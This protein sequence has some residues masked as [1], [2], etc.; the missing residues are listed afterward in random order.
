MKLNFSDLSGT[1]LSGISLNRAVIILTNLENADLTN[2]HLVNS[3]LKL[4]NLNGASL[5]EADIAY[6]FL[7]STKL[8]RTNFSCA[9][10]QETIFAD[11]D[12]SQA[13]A[14]DEVVHHGPSTIGIDSIFRSQ[15]NIPK[16][17]L[18]GA[19]V[20]DSFIQYAGSSIQS[21]TQY[22]SCFI[23]HS[24]KNQ[25]F[26]DRL[27]ADFKNNNVR[28]WLATE[29]LKI[30]DRFR[31]RIEES[32]RTYDKLLLVFSETSVNS[33]WVESEVESALERERKRTVCSSSL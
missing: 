3:D 6:A 7:D 4:A 8:A 16:I 10:L 5:R 29:D 24:T 11:V 12:L 19:G 32:I 26:V 31:T 22:Y 1:N 27:Y 20:P 15:G 28:C 18:Q 23:S 21:P 2:A 9:K 30:G 33:P 17:F 13:V 25:E 14:L